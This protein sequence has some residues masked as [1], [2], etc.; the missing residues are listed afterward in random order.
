M[1]TQL[2][3]SP[4]K[5][6]EEIKEHINLISKMTAQLGGPTDFYRLPEDSEIMKL[7][8]YEMFRYISDH[9]KFEVNGKTCVVKTLHRIDMDDFLKF[10]KQMVSGKQAY[11]LMSMRLNVDPNTGKDYL[12]VRGDVV[13][14]FG[15][16]L[17]LV[18]DEKITKLLDGYSIHETDR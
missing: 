8:E 5:R 15:Y 11:I 18:R 17:S 13:P 10:L 4:E 14:F 2:S 3:D 6:F 16:Y 1:I 7:A 9:P 12:W